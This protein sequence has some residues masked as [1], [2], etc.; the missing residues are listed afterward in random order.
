MADYDLEYYANQFK[1]NYRW[2]GEKV[3]RYYTEGP[4]LIVL[5]LSDGRNVLYNHMTDRYR[6]LPRDSHNMTEEECRQEFRL[7]LLEQINHNAMSQKTLAAKLGIS[8]ATLSR[9]I[10]GDRKVDFYTLDKM[11]R[12]L[13]CSVDDFRYVRK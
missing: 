5:E 12:I 8:E 6:F 13:N 10:S 4:F 7:R 11:A 9:Y 1:W 3:I 2:L